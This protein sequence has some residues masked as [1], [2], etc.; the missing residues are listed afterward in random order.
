MARVLVVD[1]ATTVR[2]YHCGELE[3]AGFECESAANGYEA[4]EKCLAERFELLIVDINMPVMD[5]YTFLETLRSQPSSPSLSRAAS[6]RHGRAWSPT[7]RYQDELTGMASSLLEEFCAETDEQLDAIGAELLRLELEPGNEQVVHDLLRHLHTIKGSSGLFDL[8]PLTGLV[9]AAEDLLVAVRGGGLTVTPN[10]VDD[11]LATSDRLRAWVGEVRETGSLTLK[12]T[13]SAAL[14]RRLRRWTGRPGDRGGITESTV[15]QAAAWL[16][17][18]DKA[19]V[20]AAAE[21]LKRTGAKVRIFSYIPPEDAFFRKDP[22]ALVRSVPAVDL[23][24]C[25]LEHDPG[26]DFSCA[27][28]LVATTRAEPAE[29]AAALATATG[30]VSFAELSAASFVAGPAQDPSGIARGLL[31]G[32]VDML[33]LPMPVEQRRGRMGAAAAAATGALR[34]LLPDLDPRELASAVAAAMATEDPRILRDCLVT[35]QARVAGGAEAPAPTTQAIAA[36]SPAAIPSQLQLRVDRETLDRL[37]RYTGELT[38]AA[39]ALPYLAM[40]AAEDGAPV[41]AKEI[42]ARGT[43][44]RRLTDDLQALVMGMRMLPSRR[45]STVFPAWCVNTRVS[46]ASTSGW[47]RPAARSR[48]TPTSSICSG[49]LFST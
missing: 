6:S 42:L 21:W 46:P 28:Q 38:A 32:Q 26:D 4:L 36:P 9:H 29:I 27:L 2:L 8:A 5:G 12:A 16:V 18:L 20:T 37:L 14:E 23:V 19:A 25:R 13:E 30:A 11:L 40:R 33:N 35:F 43:I 1:D 39:N 45:S 48:P 47:H 44:A 10:L 31:A 24:G 49:K 41:L 22:V 3:K 15:E 17:A 34:V 7:L